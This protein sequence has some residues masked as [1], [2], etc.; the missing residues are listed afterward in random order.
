MLTQVAYEGSEKDLPSK[1]HEPLAFLSGSFTGSELNWGMIEKEAFPIIEAL[2][3]LRHFLLNDDGFVLFT[4][5]RN[6]IFIFDP[7]S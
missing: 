2:D 3:K 4:D 6:L 7:T 1:I 5:H